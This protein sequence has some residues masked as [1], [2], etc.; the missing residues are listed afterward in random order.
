M[1]FKMAAVN[2]EW[3]SVITLQV[4]HNKLKPIRVLVN[5]QVRAD[6]NTFNSHLTVRILKLQKSIF[7]QIIK[8]GP[9]IE[10]P[11]DTFQ[12]LNFKKMQ[13]ICAFL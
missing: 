4:E 11:H 7:L 5:R 12:K 13:T 3:S 6:L 2:L 8:K 10:H 1:A 9:I